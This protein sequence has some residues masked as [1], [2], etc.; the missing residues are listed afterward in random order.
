MVFRFEKLYRNTIESI[1]NGRI[2]DYSTI[3][4]S[5]SSPLIGVGA[6]GRSFFCTP[7]TTFSMSTFWVKPS[8]GSSD[9]D[10]EWLCFGFNGDEES[11]VLPIGYELVGEVEGGSMFSVTV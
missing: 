9:A 1:A 5:A 8:S 2:R 6:V 7:G 3:S 4:L 11:S 10:I